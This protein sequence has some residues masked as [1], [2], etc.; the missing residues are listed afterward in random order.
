MV[1]RDG[2]F[3]RKQARPVLRKMPPA[4]HLMDD[5]IQGEDSRV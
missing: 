5:H 3:Q 4:K 1:A 2:A